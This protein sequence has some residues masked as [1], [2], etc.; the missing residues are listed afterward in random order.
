MQFG[1]FA[2]CTLMDTRGM[3]WWTYTGIERD[4]YSARADSEGWPQA[5]S[6]PRQASGRKPPASPAANRITV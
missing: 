4:E 3:M 2:Y 5:E 6:R 1:G